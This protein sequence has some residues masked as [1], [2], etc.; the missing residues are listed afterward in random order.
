MDK[1][2]WPEFGI[3]TMFFFLWIKGTALSL[4]LSQSFLWIRG[5]GLHW[6]YYHV[7]MEAFCH[8]RAE[9]FF[10]ACDYFCGSYFLL[11]RCFSRYRCLSQTTVGGAYRLV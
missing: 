6:Q 5:T 7:F 2:H 9:V 4:A 10:A 8:V 11:F 3:I 1:R